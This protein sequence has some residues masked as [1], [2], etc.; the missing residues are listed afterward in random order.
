[1]NAAR[2]AVLMLLCLC[3]CLLAVACTERATDAEIESACNHLETLKQGQ[4]PDEAQARINKC[5]QDLERENLTSKAAQ[6]RAKAA[7]LD[8]FWN[9][10]R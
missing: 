5:K 10:C 8:T 3:C 9:K 4:S 2:N 6:C 7:D 1:M